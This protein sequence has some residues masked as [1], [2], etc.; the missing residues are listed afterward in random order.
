VGKAGNRTN[1]EKTACCTERR[2]HGRAHPRTGTDLANGGNIWDSL[3]D[4]L[5]LGYYAKGPL[6]K[7]LYSVVFGS[8]RFQIPKNI[9]DEAEEEGIDISSDT[10][11]KFLEHPII[12]ELLEERERRI[13]A[14]EENGGIRD[15]AY[16]RWISLEECTAQN[17]KLSLLAQVAQAREM[18]LLRPVLDLAL[19]QKNDR[20]R[21]AW[22]VTRLQPEGF[23]FHFPRTSEYQLDRYPDSVH[24]S[25]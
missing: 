7:G 13:E 10:A 25:S 8:P 1:T 3:F 15:D 21:H 4:Y 19:E 18:W 16:D 20:E 9:L 2:N 23:N 11:S 12:K 22:Q 17:P 5:N 24:T 14:I 6:K